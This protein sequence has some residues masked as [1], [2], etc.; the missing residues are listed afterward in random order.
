MA[1][2]WAEVRGRVATAAGRAGRDPSEI[3]VVAVSKKHPVASIR[4]VAA[5]GATAFGENYAQDLVAKAGELDGVGIDWHFIGQLQ[6]NK[7]RHVV[8]VARLIHA[9]DSARLAREIDKRAA[10]AGV[11]QEVLVAVSLAGEEHKSGVR[12]DQVA[13]LLDALAA[14]PALRCRGLMTMPP[15][16]ENPEDSRPYYRR[17]RELRDRLA[18]SGATG[19]DELSMGTTGD[20]EVAVEEGA[21]L[22]RVGTAIF[23]PR[24]Q[25]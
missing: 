5:A 22:V 16:A 24:A 8:G 11:V 21:T 14:L 19:L 6:R 1:E 18:A 20:F 23:G 2:R 15:L 13:E 12:E 4:E 17:L 9:V 10:A 3:S 25:G 7:A